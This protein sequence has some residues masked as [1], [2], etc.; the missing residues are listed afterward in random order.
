MSSGLNDMI[1]KLDQMEKGA[2]SLEG[3][4]SIPLSELCDQKFLSKHTSGNFS[5]FNDFFKAGKFG[6]LTFEEVPDD[7]WDEWVKRSTD[8]TSWNEMIK[9]ATQAYV[10]KKLGF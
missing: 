4:H 2:K 6:N 1:K 8:F 10:S 5:N 3:T 9:S 7:K